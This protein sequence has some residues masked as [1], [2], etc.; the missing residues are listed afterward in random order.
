MREMSLWG[1]VPVAVIVGYT[2]WQYTLADTSLDR[3]V[4]GVGTI[5]SGLCLAALVNEYRKQHGNRN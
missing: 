4:F 2:S 5:V 1:L 3:W